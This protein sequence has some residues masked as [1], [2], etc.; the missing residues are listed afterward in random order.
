MARMPL[1]PLIA[2]QFALV[3]AAMDRVELRGQSKVFLEQV[4]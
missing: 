1:V 2:V 4:L 3:L